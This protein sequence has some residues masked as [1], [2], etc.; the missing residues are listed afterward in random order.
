MFLNEMWRGHSESIY[1]A[2]IQDG[3]FSCGLRCLQVQPFKLADI[4]EGIAEVQLTEWFVK[5]GGS[6]CVCVRSSFTELCAYDAC[7]GDAVKDSARL[8]S[9]LRFLNCPAV[10]F[11]FRRW[12]TFAPSRATR[13]S[14]TSGESHGIQG[15]NESNK[16]LQQCSALVDI[17][18]IS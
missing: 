8:R 10:R 7:G 12:T 11:I 16:R 9:F 5:E 17:S 18:P 6:F 2:R 4:G 15:A 14:Q 3:A 1:E 13:P